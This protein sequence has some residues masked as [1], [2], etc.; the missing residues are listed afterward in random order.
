MSE[1][2][3]MLNLLGWMAAAVVLCAIWINRSMRRERAKDR[4]SK[5]P[6]LTDL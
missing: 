1:L 6:P 5:I 2:L 3:T 4:T